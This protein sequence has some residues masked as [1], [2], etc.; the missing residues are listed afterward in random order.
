M[1]AF[2]SGVAV[3]VVVAIVSVYALDSFQ[4]STTNAYA[5]TTG[6]RL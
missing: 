2:V 4:R 1:R 5:S 6:V 3:A